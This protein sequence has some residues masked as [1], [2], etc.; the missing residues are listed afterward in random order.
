MTVKKVTMID[1][2]RAHAPL[3]AELH[4]AFTRVLRSGRFIL[5][6]EVEAFER[7]LA[8]MLGVTHAIGCSS[9]TDALLAALMALG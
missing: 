9:G 4:E 7:E 1:L 5:G 6:G 3:D 8:V 2:A